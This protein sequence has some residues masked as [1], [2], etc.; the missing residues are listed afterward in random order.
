MTLEQA[1]SYALYSDESEGTPP[2]DQSPNP[3]T[4]RELEILRLLADGL[5]TRETAQRLFLSNGTVRWYLNQIY[6]K[7]SVHSRIQAITR[8]RELKLLG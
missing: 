3:L 6:S 7:L 8:A 4:E 2:A 5:S 1:V